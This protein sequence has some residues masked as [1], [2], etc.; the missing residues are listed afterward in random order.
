MDWWRQLGQER[1]AY[2]VERGAGLACLHGRVVAEHARQ[3]RPFVTHCSNTSQMSGQAGG[4]GCVFL[5][6]SLQMF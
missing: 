2:I 3:P 6:L 1:T 5:G 4:P